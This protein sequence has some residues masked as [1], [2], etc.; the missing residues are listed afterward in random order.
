MYEN[1]GFKDIR[2]LFST[3]LTKKFIKLKKENKKLLLVCLIA[4]HGFIK[5]CMQV[6]AVNEYD[7]KSNFYPLF[8]VEKALRGFAESYENIYIIAMFAACR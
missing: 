6:L 2:T 4:G 7:E 8:P 5:D 1:R 3:G